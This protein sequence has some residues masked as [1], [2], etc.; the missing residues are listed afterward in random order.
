MEQQKRSGILNGSI[1]PLGDFDDSLPNRYA[2]LCACLFLFNEVLE[3]VQLRKALEGLI[4]MPGWQKLGSRL[5]CNVSW[6]KFV[7]KTL[8]TWL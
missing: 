3:A 5:R 7:D 1:I 2:G 8:L 4:E 6:L